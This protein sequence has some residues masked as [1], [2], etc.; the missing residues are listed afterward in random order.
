MNTKQSGKVTGRFSAR[1]TRRH[2][3][4]AS[5]AV[6]ATLTVRPSAFAQSAATPVAGEFADLVDI[7]GRSL[8]LDCR[9]SGG[10]TVILEA[11]A[12][13]DSR[14]WD[15]V[16]LPSGTTG[17]AV[18][19]EVAAF[20]RV[21]AYDRPGTFLG[22][23]LPG[24]SD[25]VPMPRTASEIV[26]DLHAL[27]AAADIPGPYVMVGHS[28]GGLIVRLYAS[29]YPDDVVGLVL[30]DAAHEDFYEAAQEVM[31]PAQWDAF[32]RPG[33]NPDYP[34]LER[35]DTD[36][37]STEMREAA[38]ASPLQ[39]VPLVVLTHGQPWDWGPEFDA[40][41]LENLWPPLQEDLASLA[42]DARLVV[43]EESGH[44]IQVQQPDLV[45]EAIRQVV[46]AVRDPDTWTNS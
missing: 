43:A 29:T 36:A 19:P 22:P 10:P 46:E 3:L 42:P 16:S 35:I 31:S 2:L 26:A 6:S 17:G 27:L 12:G 20:T 24:R 5:A 28:F 23:G 14:V 38:I 8:Y 21:C 18:L 34:D 40:A 37:S 15:T 41:A 7:G 30:V 9:G 33:A 45:T 4:A 13:N 39:P 11:G 1:F 32:V 44:F 25:A